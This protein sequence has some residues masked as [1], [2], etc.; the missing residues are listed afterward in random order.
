M[1]SLISQ[2]E[3]ILY[4][5]TIAF[6]I[7]LALGTHCRYYW[8]GSRKHPEEY[9]MGGFKFNYLASF[10][11]WMWYRLGKSQVCGEKSYYH[12][13]AIILFATS[14]RIFVLSVDCFWFIEALCKSNN[15]Y[16]DLKFT[17]L[18]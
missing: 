4:Q 16:L 2:W 1:F 12:V 11:K 7:Y 8:E 10:G 14:I 5:N 3:K 15:S 13:L 18:S 9:G 17:K 6:L